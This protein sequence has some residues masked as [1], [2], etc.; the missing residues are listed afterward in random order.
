MMEIPTTTNLALLKELQALM[1]EVR[2]VADAELLS[3]GEHHA[4]KLSAMRE[5]L[6]PAS[7]I[8]D[9]A[10]YLTRHLSHESATI[11]SEMYDSGDTEAFWQQCGEAEPYWISA[12]AM[13]LALKVFGQDPS[14]GM[15][16][17]GVSPHTDC[18]V[19]GCTP[20]TP[21]TVADRKACHGGCPLCEETIEAVFNK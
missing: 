14:T 16:Y 7:L 1:D 17:L 4:N 11:I 3:V 2:P 21:L 6:V 8:M 13:V 20:P 19:C 5:Q 15:D 9:I 10:L 12:R 18:F